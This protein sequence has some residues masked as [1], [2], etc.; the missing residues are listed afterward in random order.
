MLQLA[1]RDAAQAEAVIFPSA[2]LVI[3]LTIAVTLVSYAYIP[4]T[5]CTMRSLKAQ[6]KALSTCASHLALLCLFYGTTTSMYTQP[7]SCSSSE[8]NEVVS[9][10]HMVTIPSLNP[11]IYSLRNTDVKA[12]LKKRC[13]SLPPS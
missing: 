12:A 10:F 9:D 8:Q 6:S 5:V 7:S 4:V 1:C 3:L 2:A 13:L 11:L